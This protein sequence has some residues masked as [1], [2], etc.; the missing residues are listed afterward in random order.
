DGEHAFN[1]LSKKVPPKGESVVSFLEGQNTPVAVSTPADII[2]ETLGRQMSD[3]ILDPTGRKLRTHHRRGGD[4]VH[5]AC[6]CGC[7]EAIQA[8]FEAGEE[9][10][11]T[12]Y[13]AEALDDMIFF[14]ERHVER[15]EEYRSFAD[16]LIKFLQAQ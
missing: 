5:R 10:A 2:K 1:H 8:V 16:G 9:C 11:K 14:V 6:T 3:S 13:V 12:N 7:T 15:I 4:G